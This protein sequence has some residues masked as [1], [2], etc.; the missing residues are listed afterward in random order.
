MKILKYIESLRKSIPILSVRRTKFAKTY[1]ETRSIYISWFEFIKNLVCKDF[2]QKSGNEIC[3][4]SSFLL[5]RGAKSK[6]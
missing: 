6:V 4:L 3:P 1:A 5:Q 2:D